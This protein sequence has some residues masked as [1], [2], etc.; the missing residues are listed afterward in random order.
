M[1]NFLSLRPLLIH[2]PRI[3]R[4]RVDG[5]AHHGRVAADRVGSGLDRPD[6]GVRGGDL[7]L[8]DLREADLQGA[9]LRGAG[10]REPLRIGGESYGITQEQLEQATGD[11]T[12]KLP[13]HLKRPAHWGAKTDEQ[14]ES[15]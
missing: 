12:T 10:L 15:E 8:A 3:G 2:R 9:D 5:R 14:P 7:R 4:G 13:D 11:E 1:T 6:A